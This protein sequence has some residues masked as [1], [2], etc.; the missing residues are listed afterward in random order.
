VLQNAYYA[1]GKYN[2]IGIP[3]SVLKTGLLIP[4]MAPIPKSFKVLGGLSPVIFRCTKQGTITAVTLNEC[5]NPE[6][7]V[8]MGGYHLNLRPI[9][10][11]RS[12]KS[13]YG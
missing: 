2:A 11:N 10:A 12:L 6:E 13:A 3:L 1:F 4:L 8:D 5:K 9:V 7:L